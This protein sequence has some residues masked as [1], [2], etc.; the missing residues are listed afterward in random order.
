MGENIRERNVEDNV[1][2]LCDADRLCWAHVVAGMVTSVPE[3]K[4]RETQGSIILDIPS[5]SGRTSIQLKLRSVV[6]A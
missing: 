2:C 4:E 5:E 1:S 6:Q 3:G